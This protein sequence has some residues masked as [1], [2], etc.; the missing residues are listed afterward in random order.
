M[1]LTC[2]LLICL[3][4]FPSDAARLFHTAD[5]L[6]NAGRLDAAMAA[7]VDAADRAAE[8]SDTSSL[9]KALCVQAYISIDKGNDLEAV[10]C[11]NRCVDLYSFSEPMFM[12]SSSL[13]NIATIYHQNGDNDKAEEYIMKSINVDSRRE[14]DSILALRYLLA[15][16]I[17]YEKGDYARSME[18]VEKGRKCTSR[19]RNFNVEGRLMLVQAKCREAL[20]GP[21]PDWKVIEGEYREALKTLT[22]MVPGVFYGAVN[23]YAQEF[24]YRIGLAVAAQGKDAREYFQE[25]IDNS[26]VSQKM[27]GI[28]PMI[29]MECCRALS[30]ILLRDGDEAG[31]REY[32]DRADELSFVPY[33]R[34]MGN[35]LSL[36]QIE[37]IRR[38]KDREIEQQKSRVFN[39]VL[40]AAVLALALAGL[41]LMYRRQTLQRRQIEEKNAQLVKLGLQKD[42]LISMLQES[43][44]PASGRPGLEAIANDRVP[45]P[46]IRL[47][48]REKEVLALCCKGMT[49][50]EIAS[51]LALSVRTVESHK[52]N[53]CRKVGVNSTNELISFA[54]MSGLVR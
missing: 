21:E 26:R 47:S 38:E 10:D 50:K 18:L 12:L 52:L 30:A 13:Y 19:R 5:S 40:L 39:V 36:S 27:R 16:E 1:R 25:A 49:N 3:L 2:L 44:A 45:F 11:Y 42:R 6:Y 35:R 28:N 8:A 17:S 37:F 24:L 41:L 33:V 20:A 34:E 31:A 15:A 29:E 51:R 54:F 46:D 53:I 4:G 23:P 48:K 32:A 9:I 7:A 22:T 43:P 14:S